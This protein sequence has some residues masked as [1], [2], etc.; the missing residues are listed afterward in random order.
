M[1]WTIDGF[2]HLAHGSPAAAGQDLKSSRLAPQRSISVAL[3]KDCKTLDRKLSG[4]PVAWPVQGEM[5]VHG[6]AALPDES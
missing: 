3:D 5:R 2:N 1:D 4:A 6:Q